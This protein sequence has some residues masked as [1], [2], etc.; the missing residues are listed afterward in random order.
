MPADDS[1]QLLRIMLVDDASDHREL[2]RTI[3]ERSGRFDVV[4]EAGD[5]REALELVQ[6]HRPDVVLL[7]V[8]MPVEDGIAALPKILAAQPDTCVVMLTSMDGHRLEPIA[9]E[10]G[11]AGFLSKTLDPDRLVSGVLDAWSREA[12]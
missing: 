7:D 2:I 12:A 4:A 3:L 8:S 5:G 11:A 10:H 1:G 9:L 6:V